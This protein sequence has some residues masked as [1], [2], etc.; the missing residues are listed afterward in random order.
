MRESTRLRQPLVSFEQLIVSSPRRLPVPSRTRRTELSAPAARISGRVLRA[1][2]FANLSVVRSNKRELATAAAACAACLRPPLLCARKS[3]VP[4]SAAPG[5]HMRTQEG[6]QRRRECT[7]GRARAQVYVR[8]FGQALTL[9]ACVC[10]PCVSGAQHCR[11]VLCCALLSAYVSVRP[12]HNDGNAESA[13][14]TLHRQGSQTR[15]GG[16]KKEG[17]K[18][19]RIARESSA[20]SICGAEEGKASA[21]FQLFARAVLP[22]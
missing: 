10:C 6:N 18:R 9:V 15:R 20:T 22:E 16:E 3:R 12:A 14:Q 11:G 21:V 8:H 2:R 7:L 5:P 13:V 4:C 1:A 19:V 17:A